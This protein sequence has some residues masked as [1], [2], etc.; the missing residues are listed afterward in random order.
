MP[1]GGS[2]RCLSHDQHLAWSWLQETAG[3]RPLPDSPCALAQNPGKSPEQRDREDQGRSGQDWRA[4]A[5]VGWWWPC[6]F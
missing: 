2:V 4:L 6:P 5:E 3:A 1:H